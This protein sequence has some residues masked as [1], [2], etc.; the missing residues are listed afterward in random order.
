MDLNDIP[1]EIQVYIFKDYVGQRCISKKL[2][3][4]NYHHYLDY[5]DNQPIS[6][7]ELDCYLKSKPN[8]FISFRYD[9][10]YQ[11]NLYNYKN[12]NDYIIYYNQL[13]IY[14]LHVEMGQ[15]IQK[16]NIDEIVIEFNQDDLDFL[17]TFNILVK[18]LYHDYIDY[19]NLI[20]YCNDLNLDMIKRKRITNYV[21]KLYHRH[22]YDIEIKTINDYMLFCKMK[23][24][25]DLNIEMLYDNVNFGRD[26]LYNIQLEEITFNQYG[27]VD[28]YKDYLNS[29]RYD[30]LFDRKRLLYIINNFLF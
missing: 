12:M 8:H 29:H 2:N 24:Y 4:Y 21:L 11:F 9:M 30:H 15:S 22:V 23:H 20:F 19:N 27:I 16:K 13:G 25:T 5:F 3:E 18:R 7:Y 28:E 1:Y 10:F 14:R 26:T 17:T 6:K